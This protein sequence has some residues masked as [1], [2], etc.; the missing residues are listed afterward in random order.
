MKAIHMI[1]TLMILSL[2]SCAQREELKCICTTEYVDGRISYTE[3][4]SQD[5][6]LKGTSRKGNTTECSI[7]IESIIGGS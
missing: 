1:T 6:D 3:I 5:C 7:S 4:E 2:T